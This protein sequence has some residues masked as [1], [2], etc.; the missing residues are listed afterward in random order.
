MASCISFQSWELLSNWVVCGPSCSVPT[1]DQLPVY[2][3]M[4][5]SSE[6]SIFSISTSSSSSF[7]SL[8]S[9]SFSSSS[10]S[11]SYTSESSSACSFFSCLSS[12]LCF[13][14]TAGSF[15]ASGFDSVVED[16]VPPNNHI[17]NTA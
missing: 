4:T 6:V 14:S 2:A 12:C 5:L 8:S 13:S 10:P 16:S 15:D 9:S 11:L 3:S 7:P 1:G 17:H